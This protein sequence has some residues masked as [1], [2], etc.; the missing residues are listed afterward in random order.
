MKLELHSDHPLAQALFDW[1]SE[2]GEM[3]LVLK[4]PGLNTNSN[5]RALLRKWDW[6]RTKD[7]LTAEFESWEDYM[8]RRAALQGI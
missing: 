7:V 2:A 4:K 6:D 8:V 5:F 3:W 1:D